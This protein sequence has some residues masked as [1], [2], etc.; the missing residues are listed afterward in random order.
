MAQT[1]L[2]VEDESSIADNIVFALKTEGYRPIWK[3]LGLEAITVVRN[4]SVDLV[5]LDVGLPDTT[6]FEMC[7]TI[8]S[9]STVPIIFLTARSE[10]IDRVV[11]LE[12]GADDYVVKPFS[13]RELVARVRAILKR[14]RPLAVTTQSGTALFSLDEAKAR[15][16]YCQQLLA[17]TRHEYL[18][19]KTLLSQPE[20]VFSREQLMNLAWE[21]PE[22]S[23]DR[24]V[25][26]HI[27]MLRA[28]LRAIKPDHDPIQTHR[29]M[30]Y[31]ICS[32]CP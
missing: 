1:I 12:I 5:I 26:T 7:K 18:L 8:R 3:Q 19:L 14:T 22:T 32:S 13:P 17:L 28:K 24:T 31:S 11:G 29:G 30:G 23:L 4:D 21:S 27:K 15:I 16:T 2:I 25:D 6:G 9:F 20:R 10:E